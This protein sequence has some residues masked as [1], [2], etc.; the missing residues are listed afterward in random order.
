MQRMTHRVAALMI[1][2]AVAVGTSAASCNAKGT[3]DAPVEPVDKQ[4]NAPAHIINMPDGFPNVAVKCDQG[5]GIYVTSHGKS[6]VPPVI[7]PN[8]PRCAPG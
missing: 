1:V 4:N 7:I 8:D 6:D 3:G 2:T 5:T